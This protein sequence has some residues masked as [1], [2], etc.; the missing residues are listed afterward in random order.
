MTA[1]Q[2]EAR[3]FMFRKRKSRRLVSAQIVAPFALVQV[4]R[5]REL[6]CMFIHVAVQ[7]LRKLD[8]VNGGLARRNMTLLALHFRMFAIESVLAGGMVL[9][10]KS[11]RFPASDRMARGAL[12]PA[13]TLREL[14]T[15]WIWRVAIGALGE[16]QR[17]LEISVLVA[18][19]AG[20]FQMLADQRI[21]RL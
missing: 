13:C 2:R 16:R 8:L 20:H 4:G 17:L 9:A 15:V 21:L 5:C 14:P 1:G 6:P 12:S 3:F 18:Q 7:T 10:G 19:L 11:R